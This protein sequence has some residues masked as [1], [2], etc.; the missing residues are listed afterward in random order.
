MHE[1]RPS[2]PRARSKPPLPEAPAARDQRRAPRAAGRFRDHARSW[3]ASGN[4]APNVLDSPDGRSTGRTPSRWPSPRSLA[5]GI[6]I[7]LTGQD[8]ERGTFSQ[9]HLVLHDPTNG[10]TLHAAAARCRGATAVLRRL[11]Q[12]A[13]GGGGRRLRVR[14]QRP[15]AR[16]AG[17]LG[18]AVRRLR[19]RRPGHH[20]PVH[21]RR[22]GQV[23]A[24]AVA[25]AAAAARLRGPGPGALQR[26]AGALPAARRRGQHPRRQLHD[27]RAVLPPAA[28]PG[29]CCSTTIRAR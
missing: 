9:R 24:A 22:P 26:A 20:R 11:Q 17:A 14:L 28:P 23:G 5:D 10:A 3:P 16:G 7:R 1:H 21:R 19:Q 13:L 8:A 27:R 29:R 2:R 15:G 4:A 12:P 25:G 6:P 18:G